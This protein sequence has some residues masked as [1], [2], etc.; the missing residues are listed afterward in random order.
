M[1]SNF[2]FTPFISFNPKNKQLFTG[3]KSGGIPSGSI[4]TNILGSVIN[5]IASTYAKMKMY[6]INETIATDE[7]YAKL[8]AP[9]ITVLGDDVWT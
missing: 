6:G 2:I 4:L 9:S 3:Q 7:K 1:V 8:G 5:G